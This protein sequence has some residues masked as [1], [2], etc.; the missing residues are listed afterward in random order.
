[1]NLSIHAS[2]LLFVLILMLI[3]PAPV[4]LAAMEPIVG[5]W[6]ESADVVLQFK[7]DGKILR[8]GVEYGTWRVQNGPAGKP[9]DRQYII[10]WNNDVRLYTAKVTAHDGKLTAVGPNGVTSTIERFYRGA[11]KNPD[12]PDRP[13]AMKL[14]AAD[15]REAIL[16]ELKALRAEIPD[17]TRQRDTLREQA[18]AERAA[19]AAARAVGKI[20]SHLAVATKKDLDADALDKQISEKSARQKTL[21]GMLGMKGKRK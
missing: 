21:R 16:N 10:R 5:S 20:S 13:T 15:K 17:L 6:R 1:M 3:L 18:N 4:A 9:I 11:T 2:R 19:H 12:V 14:E 8:K 7:P